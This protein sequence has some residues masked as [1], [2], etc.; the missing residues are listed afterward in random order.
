MY[1]NTFELGSYVVK[2]ES[3]ALDERRTNQ[4]EEK[5][6]SLSE[7]CIITRSNSIG[8]EGR[9]ASAPSRGRASPLCM[10]EVVVQN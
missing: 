6:N 3:Q 4:G 8:F 7:V 10:L 2:V 1:Q 5:E 9:V